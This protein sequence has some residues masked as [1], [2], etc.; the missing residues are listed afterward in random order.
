MYEDLVD[1]RRFLTLQGD[2]IERG[3]ERFISSLMKYIGHDER[4]GFVREERGSG[5][6]SI[7][8]GYFGK[9]GKIKEM[10]ESELW[11][12]IDEKRI[13]L[14][15]YDPSRHIVD[16]VRIKIKKYS[17]GEIL[18]EHLMLS[19]SIDGSEIIMREIIKA[20]DIIDD[21][22]IEKYIFDR[23][24]EQRNVGVKY[25]EK[26]TLVDEDEWYEDGFLG[27]YTLEHRIKV[28]RPVFSDEDLYNILYEYGEV[29]RWFVTD[30]RLD[31]KILFGFENEND[32]SVMLGLRFKT[33]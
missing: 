13:E 33:I 16:P 22:E 11:S 21:F 30:K 7:E 2:V 28:N 15:M 12:I 18:P 14:R 23:V 5:D 20:E 9:V 27:P 25:V 29:Y 10:L 3:I 32:E 31:T 6:L 24:N 17:G 1:P 4:Y 19:V 8:M 26:W